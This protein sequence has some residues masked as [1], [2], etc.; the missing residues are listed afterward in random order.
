MSMISIVIVL[1]GSKRWMIAAFKAFERCHKLFL[2]DYQNLI[3]MVKKQE[4]LLAKN[5]N[6][7]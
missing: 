5:I 4:Q 7:I 1:S 2:S 6:K 3:F